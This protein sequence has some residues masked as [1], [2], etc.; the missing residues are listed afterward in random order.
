MVDGEPNEKRMPFPM[1]PG[2]HL[3]KAE[4]TRAVVAGVC[5]GVGLYAGT[6]EIPSLILNAAG[7][8]ISFTLNDLMLYEALEK[9]GR[10]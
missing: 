9:E 1:I 5:H 6:P 10:L 2:R 7:M 3:N 4:I 8:A